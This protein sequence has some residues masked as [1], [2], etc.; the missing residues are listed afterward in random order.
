VCISVPGRVIALDGAMAQVQFAYGVVRLNALMRPEVQVGNYVLAHANL[1]IEIIDED[2]A[3]QILQ[4]MQEMEAVIATE[5]TASSEETF[6]K[7]E[8]S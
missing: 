6:P 8:Q 2:E 1:I 3:M 5:P 4:A 7:E